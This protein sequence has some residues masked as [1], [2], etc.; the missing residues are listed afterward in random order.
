MVEGVLFDKL[1]KIACAL[2]QTDKPFGGIQ[3]VVTGD[4]LQL[5]PFN[6]RS[7]TELNFAFEAEEWRSCL[8]QGFNLTRTFGQ[9]DDGMLGFILLMPPFT[10]LLS[11]FPRTPK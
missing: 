9:S 1:A 6:K 8:P 2:R 11:R 4:F 3:L 5:P 7:Q 10:T